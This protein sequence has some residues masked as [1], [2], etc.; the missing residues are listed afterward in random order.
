LDKITESENLP[1]LYKIQFVPL[2]KHTTR[3]W[4]SAS[5]CCNTEIIALYSEIHSQRK[6]TAW[7]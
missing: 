4:N 7:A 2:S 6:Y 5:Q 3:L 1:V